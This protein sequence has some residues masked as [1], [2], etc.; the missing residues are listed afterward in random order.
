MKFKR[1]DTVK[2]ADGLKGK[3]TFTD[4]GRGLVAFVTTEETVGTAK[5]TEVVRKE[6]EVR[7]G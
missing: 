1:G 2:S 3:V 6:K 7:K 5:G 4:S